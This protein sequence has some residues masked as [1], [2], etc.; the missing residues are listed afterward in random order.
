MHNIM[1]VSVGSDKQFVIPLGLILPTPAN[2]I[3][4]ITTLFLPNMLIP[5]AEQS[6][7]PNHLCRYSAR[8]RGV[9]TPR[10]QHNNMIILF[11]FIDFPKK[12]FYVLLYGYLL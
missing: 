12:Q 11:V 7:G 5:T 2:V 10:Q 6:F 1:I 3:I 8:F 4:L 9:N